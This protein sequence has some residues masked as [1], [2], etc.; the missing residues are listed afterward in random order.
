MFNL[1]EALNV[2]ENEDTAVR[3]VRLLRTR[4]SSTLHSWLIKRPRPL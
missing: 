3:G 4:G 1:K 2:L